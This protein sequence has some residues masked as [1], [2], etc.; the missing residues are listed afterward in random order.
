GAA[1]AADY[2]YEET[3]ASSEFLNY[4]KNL[5]KNGDTK[6][7][8]KLSKKLHKSANDEGQF[9]TKTG[10]LDLLASLDPAKSGKLLQKAVLSP[11]VAYRNAA[12]DLA[13]EDMTSNLQTWT[14][15]L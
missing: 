12:M 1:E 6:N 3:N 5:A 9:H 14:K 7:A 15:I 8:L 4:L 2:K 13:R 10:A 11:N